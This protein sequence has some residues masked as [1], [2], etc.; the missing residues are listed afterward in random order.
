MAEG[1]K[2]ALG[3]VFKKNK[4]LPAAGGC[5]KGVMMEINAPSPGSNLHFL[6]PLYF[7]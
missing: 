7:S 1:E 3:I 2:R 4:V 6:H 5:S